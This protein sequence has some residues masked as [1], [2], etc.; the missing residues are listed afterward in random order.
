[1]AENKRNKLKFEELLIFCLAANKV[2]LK[3]VLPID[4][5]H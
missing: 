2:D 1:M 5:G 3:V 4:A